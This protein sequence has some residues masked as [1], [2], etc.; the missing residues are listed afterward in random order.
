[1]S[2]NHKKL[3]LKLAC[4]TLAGLLLFI[5]LVP[6]V[7]AG[8]EVNISGVVRDSSGAVLV[9]AN[10]SLLNAQSAIISTTKTDAQG[11]FTISNVPEGSYVLVINSQGFT[12]NRTVVNARAAG[13]PEISVTLEPRAASE[14]V[15]VTA[16]TGNVESVESISQ[17]VNVIPERQIEERAKTVLTQVA[18]EE[19]GVHLQR[20]SPTIGGIVIRGATGNKVN[21]YVD[22]VRFTTSAQRGGISTF[23]N[24]IE[25][26]SLQAVEILRGPNSA[27]Y[28]SDALG[29]SLQVLSRVPAFSVDGDNAKGQ[30][31]VFFNSADLSFGSNLTSS[32]ATKNFG[33]LTN[34]AGRRVN[35]LRPGGGIDSHNAV[36]RFFGVSSDIAIDGRLP[37]TAFTQYGGLVK[38]NW[39][40]ATGSNFIVSYLRG[41]QDGGKRYDQLLGGDG[42]LIGDLRNLMN[43]FFYFRY[44][45]VDLGWLDGF[46]ATYSFNSQ[47]EERVNQGGNGN[48]RA[49]INHEYERIN[50]NGVSAYVN[51]LI[52]SRQNLL[53]GADFYNERMHSPAFGVNPVSEAVTIR[54]PRIPD[55]ALY[56]NGGVY[57][58]DVWEAIPSMLRLTGNLRYSRVTYNSKE[59][60][61]PI[62]DG[63]R[64]W[65]DDSLDVS[66][67]TFRLGAVLTPV[68]GFSLLANVSRG[69][70]APHMTDLGALG[71]V[72]TGF[73]VSASEVSGLNGT[74]GSTAD[75]E[76][77]TTGLP[78]QQLEPETSMNYELGVRVYGDRVDTDLAVFF[79]E[80][81]NNI[82]KQSLILPPGAVGRNLGSETITEQLSN[83]V[84]FVD[85][86]TTPVLVRANFGEDQIWGIEH[87]FDLRIN[88]DWSFG[89]I[90][91]YVHTQAK[92]GVPA[93][94]GWFR[95][96]YAPAGRNFWIEPYVHAA[97]RQ[98]RLSSIDL[99]DRRTGARRT[100]GSIASFFA[101]GATARGLVDRGPDG[102]FGTNDDFLIATGETLEEIQQRVLGPALEPS[103]LFTRVPGYATFNVRGGFKLSE[104]NDLLIEF[105]N[106][107]DRNYRGVDW[108]IDGPGAGV[109]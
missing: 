82:V 5:S 22:G 46:T 77:V 27:Q 103:S 51:K 105:E 60:D 39:V 68:E 42:T 93:P 91:T 84:V 11:R 24:L 81:K 106:I 29:G 56:K 107:T 92:N 52:G 109:Y 40:P 90:L 37:D 4:H 101:N 34:I 43:D 33:L 6:A 95:V 10:I 78:V 12:E 61:A 94:D 62:V 53:F 74:V 13:I 83:G 35:T 69:F 48:P 55:N 75:D 96:R 58:Q 59:E 66:T 41:Q 19:V 30:L 38:M 18:N 108:G 7:R 63:L 86:A 57:V 36:T 100:A 2:I 85:V 99:A 47:R 28:G 21:V 26:A 15:T 32:F 79:N 16:L 73:E 70:R 65:P 64:L 8:D 23:L 1:M 9:D 45:K 97:Y 14:E 87:T 89:S 44:D 49:S 98:S 31:G 67:V 3:C 20:T 80:I 17:Q 72:G 102:V 50:V 88:R 76:A 71:L 54:R 25:P 104:R